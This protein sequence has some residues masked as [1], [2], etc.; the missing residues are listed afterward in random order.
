MIKP[1]ATRT[2]SR[3][4]ARTGKP[5]WGITAVSRRA[6]PISF[7]K[8]QACESLWPPSSI[9]H[10]QFYLTKSQSLLLLALA[11]DKK[12]TQTLKCHRHGRFGG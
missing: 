1:G 9:Y 3:V 8:L 5:L 4:R 6:I 2:H 10:E 11:L 12:R 7:K